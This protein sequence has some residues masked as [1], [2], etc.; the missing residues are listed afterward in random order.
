VD[1]A[2]DS[3]RRGHTIGP[4]AGSGEGDRVPVAQSSSGAS[5]KVPHSV[6]RTEHLPAGGNCVPSSLQCVCCQE[7]HERPPQRARR[8]A[9]FRRE[10][11]C[12][13]G[14]HARPPSSVVGRGW[15]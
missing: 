13:R 9:P 12:G 6:A 14:G 2:R 8:Q 11:V 7:A 15:G 1:F 5:R 3:I 4:P 10:R